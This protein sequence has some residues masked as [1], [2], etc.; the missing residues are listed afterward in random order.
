MQ[1]GFVRENRDRL[2]TEGIIKTPTD[3][4]NTAEDCSRALANLPP[5]K[6]VAVASHIVCWS[7]RID[8]VY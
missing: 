3:A 6:E 2:V 8:K 7:P 5:M 1:F 4:C